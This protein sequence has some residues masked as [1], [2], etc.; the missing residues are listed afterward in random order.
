[1]KK[2]LAALIALVACLVVVGAFNPDISYVYYDGYM[3]PE[4]TI[5]S[6]LSNSSSSTVSLIEVSAN[7]VIYSSFTRDYLYEEN[8]TVDLDYPIYS[9]GGRTIRFFDNEFWLVSNEIEILESYD[10]LFIND[11]HTY[12][13]DLSLADGDEFIL[14]PLSNG[15]YIVVQ[16]SI[17]TNKLETTKISSNSIVKFEEDYVRF[18]TFVDGKL[19]QTSIGQTFEATI[20][21]GDN[22]YDYIDFIKALGLISDAIEQKESGEDITDLQEEIAELL[23]IQNNQQ[24]SSDNM[25][26]VHEELETDGLEEGE[27]ISD[28]DLEDADS[29]T[30]SG[31]DNADELSEN[32]LEDGSSSAGDGSSSG[33]SSST[34]DVVDPDSTEGT[35]T[36]TGSGEEAPYAVPEISISNLDSWAYAINGDLSVADQSGALKKGITVVVYRAIKGDMVQIG[37]KE[38]YAVYDADSGTG[39]S[40]LL[41]KTLYS[42]QNFTLSTLPPDTTVYLQY[43]YTYYAESTTIVDGEETKIY[44]RLTETSD[45][46]EISTPSIEASNVNDLLLDYDTDF[47]AYSSRFQLSNMTLTNDSDYDSTLSDFDNFKK[48]LLPYISRIAVDFNDL[49]SE[50]TITSSVLKLAQSDTGTTYTSSVGTLT[51]NSA[52]SYTMTAYDKYGNVLPLNINGTDYSKYFDLVYTSKLEPTVTITEV[53]NVS[54]SLTLGI[55]VVDTDGALSQTDGVNDSLTLYV[56][57]KLGVVADLSGTWSDG[58]S[59]TSD[60]S[61]Q[62]IELENPSDNQYYEFTI[63]SLAFAKSYYINVLGN[64][65]PQPD[66]VSEP[67]LDKVSDALIGQ[68]SVYTAPITSGSLVLNT[69]IINRND[70]GATF[71]LTI[72]SSSTIDIF[73]LIDEIRMSV[74]NSTTNEEM[75]GFVLY[76]SVL[77]NIRYGDEGYEYNSETE[78]IIIYQEGNVTVELS[79]SQLQFIG[80]TLWE[81]M[82]IQEIVDDSGNVTYSD[83]VQL[84]VTIDDGSLE[85]YTE[86]TINY[87]AIVVKSGIEYEITSRLT[88]SSFI[89]KKLTPVIEPFEVFAAGDVLEFIDFQISDEDGSVLSSGLIYIQLCQGDAVLDL[90]TMYVNQ[91]PQTIR[92]EG[93]TEGLE[94]TIKIVAREYNDDTGYANYQANYQLEQYSIVAGSDITANIT[95]NSLDYVYSEMEESIKIVDYTGE[96]ITQFFIESETGGT[97]TNSKDKWTIYSST[98]DGFYSAYIDISDYVEQGYNAV[99]LDYYPDWTSDG[100][101]VSG[102][103][104]YFYDENYSTLFTVNGTSSTASQ[105]AGYIPDGTVYMRV[106]LPNTEYVKEWGLEIEAYKLP[107]EN[108][109][110]EVAANVEV[111]TDEY[112]F[113]LENTYATSSGTVESVSTNSTIRTIYQVPVT[114]GEVYFTGNYLV[115]Y[116]L[117]YNEY[118]E[119]IGYMAARSFGTFVIPDGVYYMTLSSYNYYTLTLYKLADQPTDNMYKLDSTID[120][121]DVK[122]YL[123]DDNGDSTVK[124]RIEYSS[125]INNPTFEVLEELEIDLDYLDEAYIGAMDYINEA[126]IPNSNYRL[127]VVATYNG[128][129]IELDSEEFYTDGAYIMIY[130]E[131]DF[132]KMN[133]YP[134]A[135]YLVMSDLTVDFS[136]STMLSGTIDFNGYTVTH[137]SS[138]Y[139]FYGLTNDAV[140]KNITYVKDSSTASYGLV[141]ANYGTMENIFIKTVNTME[142]EEYG[143]LLCRTLS[144]TVNNFI[145]EIGADIEFS[146]NYSAILVRYGIGSL[147][148]GYIYSMNGADILITTS[149]ERAGSLIEDAQITFEVSNIYSSYDSYFINDISDTSGFTL[150]RKTSLLNVDNY[151]HVGDFYVYENGKTTTLFSHRRIFTSNYS[152]ADLNIWHVSDN[153]YN[154]YDSYERVQTTGISTLLDYTWQDSVINE[155]DAFDVEKNVTMGFYPRLDLPV[156]MQQHQLYRYLPLVEQSQIPVIVDDQVKEGT[157]L[158]IDSGLIT[159]KMENSKEYAITQINI[160]GLTTLV[161]DQ[162]MGD[163][164]LYEVTLSV[165]VSTDTTVQKYVSA[166]DVTSIVFN[167]SGS[168]I[169][170][171]SDYTTHNVEFY[172]AI[173]ST[174]DWTSIN[175][176]MSWNY[177]IVLSSGTDSLDFEKDNVTPAATMIN[178]SK[179]SMTSTTTFTGTIDGGKYD[180]DGNLIGYYTLSGITLEDVDRAYVIY[181]LASTGSIK[182]LIIDD[183]SI[184]GKTAQA[185]EEVGFIRYSYPG[186]TIENVHI[187]NS[188]IE[189]SGRIGSLVANSNSIITNCS[190]TDTN[191]TLKTNKFDVR[192]GGMVA[193]S[194]NG[195]IANSYTRNVTITATNVNSSYGIGGL[196]GYT[197]STAIQDVYTQGSIT[198]DTSYVGGLV[199]YSASSVNTIYNVYSYVEINTTGSNVGGVLGYSISTRNANILA[200]G[201][202]FAGTTNSHRVIG[203]DYASDS[204][205]RLS[206]AYEGQTMNTLT[207]SDS[208]DAKAL[209]SSTQLTIEK[210]WNDTIAIGDSWDLSTLE[211]QALPLIYEFSGDSLVYGQENIELP[212]NSSVGVSVES[213]MYSDGEYISSFRITYEG[214]TAKE[215]IEMIEDKTISFTIEGMAMTDADLALG[216]YRYTLS[217]LTTSDSDEEAVL[218][219]INNKEVTHAYSTYKFNLYEGSTKITLV[220]DYGVLVYHEVPDLTTWNYLMSTGHDRTGE[221]FKIT[222]NIDFQTQTPTYTN[223]LIGELIGTTSN[224]GFSNISYVSTDSTNG[225]WIASVA[226]V[227]NIDFTNISLSY[228]ILPTYQE[229]SGLILDISS[230]FT[231]STIS[232]VTIDY[233][234]TYVGGISLIYQVQGELSDVV[235][236]NVTITSYGSTSRSYGVGGIASYINSKFSNVT[237]SNIYINAPYNYYVG[238]IVGSN[239]VQLSDST[240]FS[241]NIT[242]GNVELTGRTYVGGVSGFGYRSNYKEVTV[243]NAEITAS[244]TAEV[245]A[246]GIVGYYIPYDTTYDTNLTV[247]DSTISGSTTSDTSVSEVGGLFGRI[248]QAYNLYNLLAENV[249]VSSNKTAGGIVGNAQYNRIYNSAVIGSHIYQHDSDGS[250]D[251]DMI[252]AG[253]MIGVASAVNGYGSY[254][255]VVRDTEI[256]G[257]SNVGGFLGNLYAVNNVYTL[258]NIYIAEDVEVT[259]TTDN[260]GGL[261]GKAANFTISDNIAIGARVT[262]LGYTAGGVIGYVE[263]YEADGTNQR[264]IDGVYVTGSVT[265]LKYAGGVFGYINNTYKITDTMLQGIVLSADVTATEYY[266]PIVYSMYTSSY[267][268]GN[269]GYYENS[270]INGQVISEVYADDSLVFVDFLTSDDF[271]DVDTYTQYQFNEINTDHFEN[272][273]NPY[274]PYI[275]SASG[276]ILPYSNEYEGNTVGILLPTP[277]VST[278]ST[279]VYTSSVNSINIESVNESVTI[280]GVEYVFQDKDARGDTYNVITVG[281]DF[282]SDITIDNITYTKDDFIRDVMTDGSYWYFIDGSELKYGTSV[283]VTHADIKNPIHLWQGSVLCEDGS[284]YELTTPVTQAANTKIHGVVQESATPLFTYLYGLETYYNFSTNGDTVMNYRLLQYKVKEYALFTSQNTLYDGFILVEYDDKTY[285]AT[286]DK[287]TKEFTNYL[288][289]LVVGDFRLD[290]ISYISNNYSYN[291]PIVV[292]RY[293]DGSV[294]VWN[295]A[296]GTVIYES[297]PTSG[298]SAFAV[299]MLSGF[300]ASLF[301]TNITTDDSY[302]YSSNLLSSYTADSGTVAEGVGD[303][304]DNSV[305][306]FVDGDGTGVSDLVEALP[307]TASYVEGDGLYDEDEKIIIDADVTYVD[308][309]GVYID[310]QLVYVAQSISSS[311][312]SS[313]E[314][315]ISV[316]KVDVSE[317]VSSSTSDYIIA[318]NP[319]SQA[320]EAYTTEEVISGEMHQSTIN[321]DIEEYVNGSD[322]IAEEDNAESTFS[323]SQLYSVVIDTKENDSLTILGLMALFV[324]I[325]FGAVYFK[326]KKAK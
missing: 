61:V 68:D 50:I 194:G 116:I 126:L 248:H 149:A 103:Y 196:A 155:D 322:L 135:N 169:S 125:S 180:S 19:E 130:N 113:V 114:P 313:D 247:K 265:A 165:A 188:N 225:G 263:D 292:A 157:V 93:L 226:K 64:Y 167:N 315:G 314:S 267:Q 48:N 107:E 7:D 147:T 214:K 86:Y 217:S 282:K 62:T 168:N 178:G 218:L 17:F 77:N 309:E 219:I 241:E 240:T 140:L 29:D 184:T 35:G 290:N 244:S 98:A 302:S 110:V 49:D 221:N 65:D 231:N 151:Y 204:I 71:G 67:V 312:D 102:K 319:Y 87:E 298:I 227:D 317:D 32:E 230:S 266:H 286:I 234:L 239:N 172:K 10:G 160:E 88:T 275:E 92:F 156:S 279:A 261:I 277:G 60:G 198:T 123:L 154:A 100:T 57:D 197:S 284:I 24:A 202:V 245:M 293:E 23:N 223:L 159:I 192:I 148:N 318:Y 25:S 138:S 46:Y 161:I 41:R 52:H 195:M 139:L 9:N 90:Y 131:E 124:L 44:T 190:V 301:G 295:F 212:G 228:M 308:G 18:Y 143:S 28:T 271:S 79:G 191:I 72:S 31:D 127:S 55:A 310:D 213:S 171:S 45:F 305:S 3:F 162:Q 324:S 75:T 296:T 294:M 274:M 250:S 232:N 255:N 206:Y 26:S 166:Y 137:E 246:G 8:I 91:D 236:D 73:P 42:T 205:F 89:T 262:S 142:M 163:E 177:R 209:L 104:I 256:V 164:G 215:I 144:G 95:L 150:L 200:L 4:N 33:S 283:P 101:M 111:D 15:L 59:L 187:T 251:T 69:S 278:M 74:T 27:D 81:S 287:D 285:F 252:G 63:D 36:A 289:T 14:V 224:A 272:D 229:K 158:D 122:G 120:V 304:S 76:E 80:W 253:G 5:A 181:Y 237:A 133:S 21:I 146:E 22:E 264:I 20:S 260:A 58:T 121:K 222:G 303:V 132:R 326:M 136:I 153:Y 185:Y 175:D 306:D 189:A 145:V 66:G 193:Y 82:F 288:S 152:G 2:L 325:V 186:S 268:S 1:M 54:D 320:Y 233:N 94:Y 13:D 238:G 273:D 201:D 176:N 117:F 183:M 97:I 257:D 84:Q 51:S 243:S 211:D 34:E 53:S 78:S 300:S 118:G 242:V 281:Y 39:S 311:T 105:V 316:V 259:A 307:V 16:D 119:H 83:P 179:T 216:N 129:E 43:S 56:I 96:Q 70:T 128:N 85:T 11:G 182:N 40:T 323:I 270:L 269:V 207:S 115:G 258:S 141:N 99:T 276:D 108:I 220:I 47:A 208:D 249:T 297:E 291:S 299:N 210:I 106:L 134:S 203:L 112:P 173:T 174:A 280:D 12:N 6:D 235:V 30:N 321:S 37:T 170:I 38:G 254:N 199:G 109:I